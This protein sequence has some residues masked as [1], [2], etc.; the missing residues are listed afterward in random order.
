MTDADL[1][2]NVLSDVSFVAREGEVTALVGPSGGGKLTCAKLAARFWDV[3]SGRVLVGGVDVLTVDPEVLLR[4]FSVVFQDVVLFDE[5]VLD[6]IRLGRRD[7]TDEEVLAAARA[8]LCDEFVR[9]LPEGT[10]PR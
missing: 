3:D 5:S 2:E 7:A 4:D 6:N 8:A 10:P 9:R 1:A